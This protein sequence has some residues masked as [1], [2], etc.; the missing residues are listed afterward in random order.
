VNNFVDEHVGDA[1]QRLR[2][3]ASPLSEAGEFLRRVHLD[4]VGR[5][6]APDDQ[7]AFEATGGGTEARDQVIDRLLA[8]PEFVDL[9]TLHLADLLLVGGRRADEAATRAYHEWLRGE[10]QRGAPFDGIVRALLT[11]SGGL[12]AEPAANFFT[13][14][15]DPRDL[16]EHAGRMFLGTRIACA[17]CHAHPADRWTQQDYHRFAA[18]FARVAREGDRVRVGD[19]GEVDDP[20]TGRPLSPKPLGEAATPAGDSTDRRMALAQWMTSPDTERFAQTIVNRVWK[21]LLGRGLV[22]PVDDL[23][24]TNPPSH[25][26]LLNALAADFVNHNHDLRHVIRTIVRSRT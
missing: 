9:W 6:P 25:P 16:A 10:L 19:R 24:P 13:L 14:A 2:L 18:Y 7:R 23:R 3:P 1:L 12:T 17:R 15:S 5:L 21:Q 20:K 22:E 26:A 8:R 11:A 4:L